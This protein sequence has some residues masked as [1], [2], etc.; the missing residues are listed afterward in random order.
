MQTNLRAPG[1]PHD[2]FCHVELPG[3]LS[4]H[5][6]SSSQAR[7]N[8]CNDNLLIHARRGSEIPV[9]ATLL[10]GCPHR[11]SVC[12]VNTKSHAGI[13]SHAALLVWAC[14]D[15]G[16]LGA[17]MGAGAPPKKHQI[18]HPR[19]FRWLLQG[20]LPWWSTHKRSSMHPSIRRACSSG[21]SVPGRY[22]DAQSMQ[23]QTES[24]PEGS[25]CRDGPVLR[26]A[27]PALRCRLRIAHRVRRS[28]L[29]YLL[30]LLRSAPE[31]GRE[32]EDPQ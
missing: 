15:F 32:Q 13:C 14:S 19:H 26:I 30:H 8:M 11:N 25:Y 17:G 4:S 16:E 3:K 18:F 1:Q 10:T 9:L 31:R 12:S 6:C 23:D 28:F 5:F 7:L 2:V 21:T 24:P 29:A 20:I 27:S 22:L